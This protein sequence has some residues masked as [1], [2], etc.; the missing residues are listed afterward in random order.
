MDRSRWYF[1]PLTIFVVSILAL[2]TSLILYIYW[3]IEISAGLKSVVRRFNLDSSQILTAQTWVVILVLSILVG[4]ILLGLFTIFVYS[5]KMVQ[6]YRLQHN[7]INNFTHEL[8]TPVASI[9]L[10][11]ETFQKHELGRDDQLKYINYMLADV[12][13]LSGNISRILNLARIESKSFADEFSWGDPLE[14]IDKFIQKNSHLFAGCRIRFNKRPERKIRCHINRSLFEILLMNLMTNAINYRSSKPPEIDIK[15]RLQSS[16]LQIVFADNG[17]GFDRNERNKIF[18]K[19]YQ[20]GKSDD[21][22][23]KGSGIGLYMAQNIAKIHKGKLSANSSGVDQGAVFTLT[24]PLYK[25]R[26]FA[27]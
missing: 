6:L 25:E 26:N 14:V 9:R 19:F 27:S 22:S 16:R 10:Y 24:L 13:R 5:Q 20:V 21:M 7:F 18:K 17:I 23:A 12:T 11:L 2:G 8:K 1:H 4:L 3:Y 15:A